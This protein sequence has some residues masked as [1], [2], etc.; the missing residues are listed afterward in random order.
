MRTEVLVI[1]AGVSGLT[2][3][4]RLVEAGVRTAVVEA[5]S[6]VGGR[7][8]TFRPADGGPSL[9]LGAQVVHGDLNPVH[10]IVNT[11]TAPRPTAARVVS[12][13]VGR[14]MGALARTPNPPWALEARLNAEGAGIGESVND[15]LVDRG[16]PYPVASE[17][18]R[19][20]W[21]TD[22]ERLSARGVAE[23]HR[24]DTAG[25]GEFVVS[26]GFDLLARRLAAGLDVRTD[27]PVQV[28]GW[29]PGRV[30]AQT[31]AGVVEAERVVVTVPPSVVT[32]GTLTVKDL[33][34]PKVEA[35][36]ALAG[37]DGCCVVATL[38]VP[39]PETA[40]VFDADGIGGFV[41]CREGRPE[42][43][44]VARDAAAAHVRAATAGSGPAT[45]SSPGSGLA[46]LLAVALPWAA[47]AEVV[48][49]E[50]A[51]WG[52]DPW[53]RGAFTAPTVGAEWAPVIWAEPV[54]DTLFFAGEA[55]VS[56]TRLPWVQGAIASG[57]IAADRL[58]EAMG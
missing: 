37:G 11:E 27:C 24:G 41:S 22:P 57:V 38:S 58:L 40:S 17:W 34:E 55:T 9:E 28:L 56:G 12:G 2:C 39:A 6:R 50:V 51:D 49:I 19:Q 54:A 30:S 43:L 47:R 31:P 10:K 44:I 3:A 1:G 45:A 48:D 8:R 20:I 29:S 36:R 14:P 21:A 26:G 32:H 13:R 35:A 4:T 23:A 25:R 46:T 52:A 7:I 33:P 5:R 42:A 18:F 16:G 53:S 15:W